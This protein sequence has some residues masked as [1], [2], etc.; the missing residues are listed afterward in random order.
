MFSTVT[1]SPY[2]LA[3]LGFYDDWPVRVWTV[4]MPTPGDA[5]TFGCSEFFGGRVASTVAER[6]EIRFTV[7]SFL[8]V[9]NQNVPT[10]V[11]ELTNTLAAYRGAT[12]PAGLSVVPQFK[13][14]EGSSTKTILGECLSPTPGQIFSTDAFQFGYLVFNSGGAATLGGMWSAVATNYGST[15]YN[16]FVLF[17]DLP[18]APTPN[19]D[20][21][22]VSAAFPLNKDDGQYVGFPYVP[23]P[24]TAI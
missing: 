24:E 10:N 11:I 3:R 14:R 1:A 6:G 9:I 2:Q 19:A 22:Y 15:P 20:T 16:V 4:Y 17:S 7:N 5:D 21:F 23:S 13:V 12:P 18:W 8:D